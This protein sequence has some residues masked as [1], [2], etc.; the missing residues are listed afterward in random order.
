MEPSHAND[1]HW[2]SRAAL[3]DTIRFLGL[4]SQQDDDADQLFPCSMDYAE[5]GL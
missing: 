1:R 5:H 2:A 3:I 4:D